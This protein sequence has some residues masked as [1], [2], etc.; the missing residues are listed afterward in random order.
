M[1]KKKKILIL[2]LFVSGA[3]C[4]QNVPPAVAPI[5]EKTAQKYHA[6]SSFSLDFK[7]NIEEDGE[8]NENFKGVLFVKKD[9]YFLTFEDQIIANDGKIMWNYQKNTNEVA[10]FEAEDDDFSMFHP[11]KMLNNWDKEYSAKFIREEELQKKRVFVIDL[12]PKKKM[13]FYKIRLFINKETHHIQQIMMYEPDGATITYAI[14][15]FTPNAAISDGKFIFNK[16]DFPDVEVI[17]MR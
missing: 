14:T 9:K 2:L 6:L 15:K 4:A 12:T 5:L 8:K 11:T 16:N 17:D 10:L 13:P 7:V 1:I 3:L